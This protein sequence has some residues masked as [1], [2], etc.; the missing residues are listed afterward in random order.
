MP[1]FKYHA[2]SFSGKISQGLVEA[3]NE[4]EARMKIRTKKLIPVK[5]TIGYATR[6]SS[7]EEAIKSKGMT[8][9]FSKVKTKDL[10]IFT[11]Q[12]SVLITSGIP[13]LQALETL[14]QSKRGYVLDGALK[15]IVADIS[16]GKKLGEA[17]RAHPNV[18]NNFYVN[19]LVAGEEGGILDKV[20]LR[21]S[22][23]IE[24]TAKLQ[25]KIKGAAVYPV[26]VLFI[27]LA[28]IAGLLV[29]VIPK[30][31]TM[32]EGSGMDLPYLTQMTIAMSE[33]VRTEWHILL[34][35]LIG[36]GVSSRIYVH[37]KEG[38]DRFHGMLVRAPVF[39]NFIVKSSM[40][41]F[42]RT[43]SSLLSAG[44]PIIDAL[45]IASST[46]G[47]S[48]I[49]R[50]LEEGKVAVAKGKQLSQ[51]L[52]KTKIIPHMVVQMIAVGE[53]TGAL[54][55]MLSKVADFYE[56]E[57]DTA[58]SSITSLM[59]PVLIIFLGGIIAFFVIAMYLP[60]FNMAGA[61]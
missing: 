30:F 6:N 38:K 15:Q 56:D 9:R 60:I 19:M 27:S 57:V 36:F 10:Q 34:F 59:E 46:V 20:L 44:V 39:G 8:L 14:S 28:V 22:M 45:T 2:K 26:V 51:S 23:H 29:F 12:L 47:N 5:V 58:V 54:D 53:G 16:G 50:I 32:F 18:F 48:V 49:T 13:L 17:F 37:T 61:V 3:E 4:S 1:T 25:R 41:K 55:E 21:M 33:F 35:C 43:L 11:R 31:V 7:K 52:G 40:A 42:S 24:K